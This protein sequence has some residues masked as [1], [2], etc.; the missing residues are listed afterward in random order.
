MNAP[1][2]EVV[3]KDDGWHVV[4]YANDGTELLDGNAYPSK[5]EAL[6]RWREIMRATGAIAVGLPPEKHN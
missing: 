4:F 2:G 6:R 5:D 1:Y 3:Q